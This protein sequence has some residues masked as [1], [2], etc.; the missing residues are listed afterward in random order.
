MKYYK[1]LSI[2]FKVKN[3]EDHYFFSWFILK[4]LIDIKVSMTP[5]VT[6]NPD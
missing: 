1:Y 3:R 4:I 2:F 6:N 5:F